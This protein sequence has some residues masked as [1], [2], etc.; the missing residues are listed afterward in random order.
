M[1]ITV[2]EKTTIKHYE[3]TINTHLYYTLFNNVRI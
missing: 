1:R 3:K 2:S